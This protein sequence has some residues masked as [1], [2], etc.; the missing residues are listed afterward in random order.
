[1]T[2]ILI[3]LPQYEYWCSGTKVTASALKIR[4]VFIVERGV[5]LHFEDEK[6]APTLMTEEWSKAR[7]PAAG[8]HLVFVGDEPTCFDECDF[9]AIFTPVQETAS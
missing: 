5:E 6:F 4:N 2:D 1:M 3:P 9:E 8:R 7:K